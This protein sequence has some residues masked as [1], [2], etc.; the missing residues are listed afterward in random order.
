MRIFGLLVALTIVGCRSKAAPTPSA[1]AAT[2]AS[3]APADGTAAFWKWFQ[4]NADGLR[5]DADL[6]HTMERI[7]TELEKGH[8]G[9]F[10]EIGADGA[11]RL[12]VLSVDGDKKLFPLVQQL[13]KARPTV[14]GWTV[15]AFRQ[16]DK[17]LTVIEM[18][19]RKLDPKSMKVVAEKNGE[20]FDV[21][22]YVPGFTTTEDFGSILFITLDHTVGEYDMETRI[23]AI[24][25]V[26]LDK[27]PA[28]ARPLAEL[29]KLIDESF[30]R[31]ALP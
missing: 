20:V 8:K 2:S 29:P 22:V 24:D 19:G 26:S 17:D 3:T 11:N 30:P 18:G 25:W 23:G 27:A 5:A 12:L 10:A 15:A 4:K 7:S 28:T 21:T 9:V 6:Q 16:R 31:P 14:E 13:Y 1:T